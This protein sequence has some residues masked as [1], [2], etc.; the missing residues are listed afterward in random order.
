V[1]YIYRGTRE[2]A[3]TPHLHRAGCTATAGGGVTLGKLAVLLTAV[4]LAATG[5]LVLKHGMVEAQRTA[6]ASARPLLVVAASS[7]WIIGGLMI[8]AASSIGWLLTLA[9]VPLSVAYPFNAV[10]YVAILIAS[11]LVLNE[12][13]NLWMW[14]GT[15]LVG[16]GLVL[17]VVMA[18]TSSA[19][20][21]TPPEVRKLA[22][23]VGTGVARNVPVPGS[24]PLAPDQTN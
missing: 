8:F 20:P 17:I 23:N 22:T 1:R 7:P 5:Q 13:T 15:V 10:G 21:I 14:L 4:A 2:L 24:T 16:A 3:E 11:T 6:H 19:S 9:R 18:P 12:R